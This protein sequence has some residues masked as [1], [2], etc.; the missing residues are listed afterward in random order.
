MTMFRHEFEL[1]AEGTSSVALSCADS[2]TMNDVLR[3]MAERRGGYSHPMCFRPFRDTSAPSVG[4]WPGREQGPEEKSH[5]SLSIA[6]LPAR[7]AA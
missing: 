3:T 5:T 7:N 2:I 4:A 1:I 6:V